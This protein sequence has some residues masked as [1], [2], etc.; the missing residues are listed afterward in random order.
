[1]QTDAGRRIKRAYI[2]DILLKIQELQ[3]SGLNEEMRLTLLETN[4]KTRK[5][6]SHDDLAIFELLKYWGYPEKVYKEYLEELK[7]KGQDVDIESSS[8]SSS[9]SDSSSDSSD[10]SRKK[11]KKKNKKDKKKKRDKFDRATHAS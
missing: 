4:R 9:D 2:V 5:E 11:R 10:S 1:M 7:S 3:H 6:F 8:S